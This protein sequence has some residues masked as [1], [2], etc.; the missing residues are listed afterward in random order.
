MADG[1]KFSTEQNKA[2]DPGLNVWVQANAGTG[3]TSVLT[4]RLLRILFRGNLRDQGRAEAGA[5]GAGRGVLC[6]TYTNAGAAE[7]R[8]RILG[9]LREWVCADDVDLREMLVGIAHEKTPADED[10][11]AARQIFYN[12][13][14]NPGS[15]KIKTIH[16]FCEE[17]LRRFPMEAGI[18]PAWSLVQDDTRR[19]LLLDAFHELI[20]SNSGTHI[21]DAFSRILSRTSEY[22]FDDLLVILTGRYKQF[23]QVE[24]IINY[25]KQFI[26]TAME[27]LKLN[28]PT[29]T[30]ESVEKLQKIIELAENEVKSFKKPVGYLINIIN[31]TRQ[32]VDKSIY[33]EEYENAY[34]TA[35]G[36]KIANVAKKDYLTAEQDRVFAIEQRR[37]D[38]EIFDDT[39]ALF[40]LSASFAQKYK[41]LKSARNLLDFDDLILCVRN[42][43]AKPDVMGWVLSQLD[44]P[45]SHILVD[46]AQDTSPEQWDIMKA[47][48]ADFFTEGDLPENTRSLFIVGDTK[49]SIYGFQGADPDAFAASREDIGA[50]IK[51]SLR[52]IQEVPLAQNFRSAAPILQAA[53][54]FFSRLPGF[55]RSDHKCF[56]ENAPGIVEIHKLHSPG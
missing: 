21:S 22:S 45:L 37:L 46:E 12:Y 24:N 31:Y 35:S 2:S 5:P 44:L 32:Y 33:F 17:I 42:L 14:D 41:E 20:N 27:Y 36:T 11:A 47:L 48:S 49:Q 40:D 30:E 53:D 19:R 10:L 55:A 28:T 1:Q 4:H 6:L 51:N 26:D 25:R 43:F 38:Q 7:M 54:Y 15:L 13:I 39:I 3:K 29:Q 50:Q 18:S 16:G 9:A 23:F 34:L 8:N 52:A 56:R